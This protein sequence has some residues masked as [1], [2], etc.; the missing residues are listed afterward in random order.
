MNLDSVGGTVELAAVGVPVGIGNPMFMGVENII[1]NILYGI[2]AVKGVSFG[3]GFEYGLM[4]GSEANDDMYYDQNGNVCTLTNNCGGITGGITNGM[5]IIVKAALKP[6]PSIAQNQQTVNLK[7][8]E[9]E[10]LNIEGRHDPCI[11][12]RAL[13]ALEA[14]FAIGLCDL[15]GMEGKL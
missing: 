13:P 5:P 8:G 2:P 3:R 11:V 14:A 10:N 9:N 4:R 6:T 15:L 12:A 7:T 1:S